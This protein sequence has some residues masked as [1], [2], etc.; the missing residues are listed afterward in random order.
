MRLRML[1]TERASRDGL[2]V[3][4]LEEGKAYEMQ[5]RHE[6][7]VAASLIR[8][9]CA[10]D[11]TATPAEVLARPDTAEPGIQISGQTADGDVLPPAVEKRKPGRRKG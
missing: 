6:L 11:E 4:T 7:R 10:E 2:T 8:M 3:E 5:T 9:G 1:K